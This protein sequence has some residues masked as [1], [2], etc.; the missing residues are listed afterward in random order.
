MA[1]LMRII[2]ELNT[3]EVEFTSNNNTSTT[4]RAVVIHLKRLLTLDTPES[5][6]IDGNKH[7]IP[8]CPYCG[9]DSYLFNR[10]GERNKRCG[11]CGKS[12]DW[13]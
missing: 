4:E 8:S 2:D 9:S 7:N 13:D 6:Y 11:Y 12:L 10:N 5:P 1:D 3:G